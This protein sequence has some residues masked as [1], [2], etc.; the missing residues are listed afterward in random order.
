RHYEVGVRIGA[1][2]LG[3]GFNGV[4]SWGLV[5]NR[6][7]LRCL[8]GYG[9]CLWRLG[10][11]DEAA[12]VCDRMLWMNRAGNQGIRFLLPAVRDGKRWEESV[13]Y[14]A[15]LRSASRWRRRPWTI[16]PPGVSSTSSPTPLTHSWSARS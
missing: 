1:L 9:L 5:D 10:R 7:F 15:R 3:E 13:S 6:P 4:L 2:S 8:K 12:R 11:R 16:L 14:T